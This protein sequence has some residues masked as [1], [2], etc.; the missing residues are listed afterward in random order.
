MNWKKILRKVGRLFLLSIC[1]IGLGI[2]I[3]DWVVNHYTQDQRYNSIA[4]MPKNKV[5][6]VLGTSKYTSTGYLNPYYK[7]RIRAAVELFKAGKVEY[8]LLSGDNSQQSYNE[9]I[10]MKKDLIKAGVPVEKLVLDYAGFRTLD[11]VI[12][13]KKVFGQQSITIISQPF[14]NARALYI[15]QSQDLNAVAYDAR[16]VS[17]RYGLRV[18]FREK[19]ARVK[20][21]LDLLI[22]KQPH[23]LGERIE[24]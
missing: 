8:L 17:L 3:C 7:Y 9:P 2:F 6:L 13:S 19:L 4:E 1:L 5:G 11:S 21:F 18:Q 16:D 15:A 23:F 14:H 10:Q 22:N 24:I 20:M 12:R